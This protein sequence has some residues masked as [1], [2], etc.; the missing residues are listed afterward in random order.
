MP[1]KKYKNPAI[2]GG[3]SCDQ[4]DKDSFDRLCEAY[5]HKASD[6]FLKIFNEWKEAKGVKS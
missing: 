1:A 3:F 5:G 2:V 6:M 4:N